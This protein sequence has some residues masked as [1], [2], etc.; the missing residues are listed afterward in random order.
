MRRFIQTTAVEDRQIQPRQQVDLLEE[1]KQ[2]PD[3]QASLLGPKRFDIK[4]GIEGRFRRIDLAQE[5][6]T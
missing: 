6:V 4:I 5:A 2:I 3:A 1:D